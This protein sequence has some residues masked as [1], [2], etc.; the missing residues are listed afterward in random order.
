M[1]APNDST[2]RSTRAVVHIQGRWRRIALVY[3]VALGGAELTLRWSITASMVC[4]ALLLLG[5]VNHYVAAASP[6]R[7][8]DEWR[9]PLGHPVSSLPVLG[10][11]PILRIASL[12]TANTQVAPVAGYALVAIPLLVGVIMMARLLGA[13][14]ADVGLRWTATQPVIGLI[15]VPLTVVAREL[16]PGSPIVRSDDWRYALLACS[17]LLLVGGVE[18]V[19]FRGMVQRSLCRLFGA[20]GVFLTAGLSAAAATGSGSFAFVTFIGGASL[21]FGWLAYRTG[22]VIGVAVAR[23]SV[24]VAVLLLGGTAVSR[25]GF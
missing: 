5:L 9:P 17:V 15:A 11:V 22:S 13:S 8:A 23:G 1:A 12:A 18:E 2:S 19:I 20:G 25:F 16:P 7:V 4:H 3:L 6:Q 21:V 10:L 14:P 24:N